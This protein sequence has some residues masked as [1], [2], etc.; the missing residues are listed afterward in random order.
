[1]GTILSKKVCNKID[2]FEGG[3]EIEKPKLCIIY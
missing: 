3:F 1:M 2:D